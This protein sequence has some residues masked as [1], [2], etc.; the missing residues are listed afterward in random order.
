V[1][2]II[3][4]FVSSNCLI[5]SLCSAAFS[6]I[7]EDL[8]PEITMIQ[9]LK[10]DAD[11]NTANLDLLVHLLTFPGSIGAVNEFLH[12]YLEVSLLPSSAVGYFSAD[13]QYELSFDAAS[14]DF[15]AQAFAL[16]Q[17][18]SKV[19]EYR[20]T[21]GNGRYDEGEEVSSINLGAVSW[22]PSTLE[23]IDAGGKVVYHIVAHTS[24]N[25]V[26][27]TCD[28]STFPVKDAQGQIVSPNATKCTID[29]TDYPFTA[30]DTLLAMEANVVLV[31]GTFSAS[32]EGEVS[33]VSLGVEPALPELEGGEFNWV[34]T[35]SADGAQF[36]V[37]GA[38]SLS[39]SNGIVDFTSDLLVTAAGDY[40]KDAR[41]LVFSF[42]TPPNPAQ[43]NWDPAVVYGE[44]A[45]EIGAA[46]TLSFALSPFIFALLVALWG[47]F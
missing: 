9:S 8:L 5:P 45:S 14:L 13:A 6:A 23:T 44:P 35:V 25:V 15:S 47:F 24:D 28:T 34:S 36:E 43:V 22:A 20:D 18:Y 10:A 40:T 30:A 11:E 31:G 16:H 1:E 19:I 4:N 3:T 42:Q 17:S 39:A 2:S 12:D 26:S 7:V 37:V 21:N 27:F 32:V 46:S 29:I 41:K 33:G 38:A